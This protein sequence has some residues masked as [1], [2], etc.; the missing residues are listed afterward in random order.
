[1]S[2]TLPQAP[3]TRRADLAELVAALGA[4]N[5]RWVGGAVR[6]TLLDLPVADID[7]A[8]TLLPDE[9]QTRLEAAQIRAV[10]TG[11]DHGTITAVCAAGPVEITTLR[12]DVATDGRRAT[13]AF[14]SD[15]RDDAARRDFT[16]NALY[17]HPETRVISDYF[18][19]LE[20]LSH[21]RVRFIG[22]AHERIREDHLRI[23]RYFRFHARFGADLDPQAA[24]ACRDL[25]RTLKGLSRE[26]V[27]K[28]LLALLALPDPTH[29][30]RL[31]DD[32]G[33]WRVLL[34]ETG[35][36]EF[37]LLTT[38]VEAER[39][40]DMAPNPIRRVAALLPADTKIAEAIGTRFRLSR[41][42]RARLNSAAKR[43]N[44]DTDNAR[45][46]AYRIG[47]EEAIDRLLLLNSD[48][49]ALLHWTAPRLPLKGGEIVQHG[50]D[51]G[52]EVA[53]I[54]RKVETVWID[55]NFPDRTRVE[56]ILTDVLATRNSPQT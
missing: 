45:T 10:P 50:V 37:A 38:L 25:A 23:L 21:R 54:L 8:T 35:P 5:M 44:N 13:I 18:G 24:D 39:K 19:G 1:M 14:A 42:Q 33:V 52:P 55:E 34:P 17:A 49:S 9:V 15:W 32:L 48:P 20:D 41:A 36:S 43:D 3:W 46:L 28:E 51:A 4:S 27:A 53:A 26:R 40:A 56:A 11:I 47:V 7:A 30:V 16:M 22:N 2:R 31:M 29:T 6:D 12:R